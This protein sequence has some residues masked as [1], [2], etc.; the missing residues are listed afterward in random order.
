MCASTITPRPISPSSTACGTNAIAAIGQF[1]QQAVAVGEDAGADRCHQGV[2]DAVDRAGFDADPGWRAGN[3]VH[4][5][6]Q[7]GVLERDEP[8]GLSLIVVDYVLTYRSGCKSV[9]TPSNFELN[10][11]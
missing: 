6:Q 7:P 10:A 8:H 9:E 2:V 1:L 3:D 11:V 5:E 4:A